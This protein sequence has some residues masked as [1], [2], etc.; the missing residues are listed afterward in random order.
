MSS[1]LLETMLLGLLLVEAWLFG[2]LSSLNLLRR[3][4]KSLLDK[5][6]FFVALCDEL[7]MVGD[8]EGVELEDLTFSGVTM[9]S[10]CWKDSLQR[11]QCLVVQDSAQ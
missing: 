9:L 3:P 2:K 5:L 6:V 1:G 7:A 11:L 8:L 4:D 10:I